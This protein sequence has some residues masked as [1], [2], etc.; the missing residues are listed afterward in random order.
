MIVVDPS[1]VKVR[2]FINHS[3][4]KKAKIEIVDSSSNHLARYKSS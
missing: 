1:K 4:G 2:T 3:V